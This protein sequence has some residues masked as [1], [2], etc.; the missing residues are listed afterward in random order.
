MVAHPRFYYDYTRQELRHAL[1]RA[2]VTILEDVLQFL[3]DDPMTHGSGYMKTDMWRS[4]RRYTLD[5]G[6]ITRLENAVFNYLRRP[7]EREFKPMCHVLSEI[8]TPDFWSRVA[9]KVTSDHPTERVNAR[10]LYA[11]ADGLMAGERHRLNTIRLRTRY[12]KK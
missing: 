4:I 7:M 8:G 2:D 5:S 11:Y 6:Q 12:L 1:K 10:C 9:E 3:E